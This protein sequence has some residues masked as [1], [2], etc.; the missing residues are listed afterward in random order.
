M[1]GLGS[2]QQLLLHDGD[3]ELAFLQGFAG[4]AANQVP[5]GRRYG[6]I[7]WLRRSSYHPGPADCEHGVLSVN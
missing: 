1:D 5:E 6:R 3:E 7:Q 2:P 4:V